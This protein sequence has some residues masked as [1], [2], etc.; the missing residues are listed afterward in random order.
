[1]S[2]FLA[3]IMNTDGQAD[4]G[5]KKT[6]AGEDR[7]TDTG[8]ERGLGGGQIDSKNPGMLDL[9]MTDFRCVDRQG[10]FPSDQDQGCQQ[11]A[12][13]E[14][15]QLWELPGNLAGEGAYDRSWRSAVIGHADWSLRGKGQGED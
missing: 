14:N 7:G 12:K 5:G 6:R 11:Q 9:R 10:D 3:A 8:V 13:S 15:Q 1:M 2:A 4:Y